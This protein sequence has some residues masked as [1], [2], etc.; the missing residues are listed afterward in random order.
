MSSTIAAV[1]TPPGR[2][3]IGIVRLSGRTSHDVA[4]R[5]AHQKFEPRRATLA[6]FLG[7]DGTPIDTGLVLWFQ[8]P[9]SYTGED[10][11]EL[12]GHGSPVV[13]EM[14]LNRVCELGA[15]PANPGEFTERAF[16]NGR[17]DLAQAE[18]VADLIQ[19]SSEEGS[20]AAQRSLR[21]EFSDAVRGVGE[22]LLRIRVH[23]EAALDFPEEEIDFLAEPALTATVEEAILRLH[24]VIRKSNSGSLLVS[25]VRIAIGGSPNVGKSSLLNRL[26]GHDRAIVTPAAG[27]TRDVVEGQ[28]FIRGM[29]VT[30]ADTAGLRETNDP[31]EVLGME[32]AH[33]AFRDSD[34]ILWL[35]DDRQTDALPP[36]ARPLIHV[37]NKCDLSGNPPG[38]LEDGSVRTCALTGL[39]LERLQEAIAKKAGLVS[40]DAVFAGRPRHLTCL[41]AAAKEV[42]AGLD[43][44]GLGNGDLAAESFRLA[45]EQL[46]RIVGETTSDDLLGEIFST[47]CIGK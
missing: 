24:E 37:R 38:R 30:V 35:T 42:R 19:S 29:P 32:R 43:Q 44:L 28:F 13:M 27:T 2:G 7:E 3:G 26:V 46:G 17:L 18:A 25:G 16:L 23:V 8:A 36:L 47:F 10:V 41:R 11:I 6:S 9:R 12:H 40:G 15:R 4:S 34:C 1:A 33:A 20:R 5:L 21:G 45:Q 22:L 14:L 31:I 39:G